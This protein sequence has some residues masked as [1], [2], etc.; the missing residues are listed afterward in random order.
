[1]LRAFVLLTLLGF[2]WTSQAQAGGCCCPSCGCRAVKKV[3]VCV[4]DV[5]K[6]TKFEFTA[7]CEDFCVPGPSHI[8]G[9]CHKK[10]CRGCDVCC[11]IRQPTCADVKSRV[12][13]MKIPVTCETPT[14]KWIVKTVCCKCGACCG[15]Q[16]DSCVAAD[17]QP[18][19]TTVSQ[20][21]T[22]PAVS[23][24]ERPAVS[25]VERP[26]VAP[27]RQPVAATS[28]L[29]LEQPGVPPLPPEVPTA[30]PASY[31]G[32]STLVELL[33]AEEK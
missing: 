17:G 5:K 15:N 20:S 22:T 1:M 28:V 19:T 16:G 31:T 23:T 8:V 26:A 12:K 14:V 25:G 24:V 30:V 32:S 6:E 33:S 9:H 29:P 21:G 3:C 4:P 27:L 11:P 13:L 18:C 10:D 7:V 2:G